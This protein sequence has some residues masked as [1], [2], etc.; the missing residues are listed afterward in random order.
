MTSLFVDTFFTL[1]VLVVLFSCAGWLWSRLKSKF[2]DPNVQQ[3]GERWS[4]IDSRKCSSGSVLLLRSEN[5]GTWLLQI[6]PDDE[7]PSK[8][9][10]NLTEAQARAAFLTTPVM[11]PYC[12]TS[13]QTYMSNELSLV[14]SAYTLFKKRSL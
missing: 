6:T 13:L 12:A 3:P 5:D 14:I 10:R 7:G 8:L 1:V 9:R 11:A 2:L 4:V